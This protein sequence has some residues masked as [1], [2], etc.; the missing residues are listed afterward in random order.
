M[1]KTNVTGKA[2]DFP[3]LKRIYAF[4]K[5]YK[6]EFWISVVLTLMLAGISPVRPILVQYTVDHFILHPDKEGLLRMT[7]LMIG[8]LLFQSVVHYFH[9]YITNWLGQ[10]IIKD[11]RVKLFNHISRLRLKYFDHTPIGTLVTRTISDLE[12]I[13]DIF[14]EGLIVIL[15]DLLQLIVIIIVMFFI[16]WRLTLISLSTIPFLLLATRV[17]QQGIKEAFREV[18]TQVAALNT[19]V[20][21]HITGMNI[22]QI[23]NREEEEQRRFETINRK[24]MKAHIKSVWYY[25]IFFPV[26]E[27]LT[28]TSIGL[29]VW[30]GSKGTIQGDVSLGNVIAFIM[31]INLLFRPIRELA[32]KFNTLQMGMVSSERVFK[33][34]DTQEFI[35]DQGTIE[36]RELRGKIEFRNIW[37]SYAD[38]APQNSTGHGNIADPDWILKNISFRVNPGETLA[39][40]GATGAGKSSIIN[41][42]GRLYDYQKGEIFIDDVDIRD[43]SLESIRRKIAIVLQDVFLFSDTIANN[44]SLRDQS[45]SMEQIVDAAKAVGAHRFI[46]KLPG[47]YNFNVMERGAMLSVGQRQLISFIRAYVFN[48]RILILDEATSSIDSESEELIQEAT[49]QLTKNR[50]SIVIAHRLST[51]QNANKIIVM[52]K[53]EIKEEGNHQELLKH[54]GLYKHLYEIQFSGIGK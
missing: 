17:F 38:H 13:A 15:G 16:D 47:Q 52:D 20:Q 6:R 49:R 36:A 30:W 1:S 4:T 23:F 21:E 42:V 33:V 12:T 51:I 9:S 3:I 32:D 18:R 34:L 5:P 37:F 28:A 44:I 22:V 26:V 54:N 14:S 11:L 10:V 29:L 19:F 35:P 7:L 53:G 46:E 48:P 41:L 24:H 43:Y 8:L 50:T 31:Y 25:S 2:F 40:V 39:L 27:L 45:I